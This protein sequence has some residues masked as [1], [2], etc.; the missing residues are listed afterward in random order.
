MRIYGTLISIV[1]MLLSFSCKEEVDELVN[2]V[3]ETPGDSVNAPSIPSSLQIISTTLEYSNNPTPQ[4]R[5]SGVQIG[6]LV[7]VYTNRECTNLVGSGYASSNYADITISALSS[8][9]SYSFYSNSLNS[10]DQASDCSSASVNYTLDRVPPNL[11]TNIFINHPTSVE[12]NDPTPNITVEG[13]SSG[14][15]VKIFSDSSCTSIK[16]TATA[17]SSSVEVTSSEV[18]EGTHKFYVLSSDLAG[19]SSS[20][21][22]SFATY[23]YPE[24]SFIF[25]TSWSINGK[26]S[27]QEDKFNDL[28]LDGKGDIYATGNTKAVLPSIVIGGP[29][30]LV[31]KLTNSGELLWARHIGYFESEYK[32]D[33]ISD[34]HSEE[35]YSISIDSN[36]YPYIGGKTTNDFVYERSPHPTHGSTFADALVAKIDPSDGEIIWAKQFGSYHAD[37]VTDM[38]INSQGDIIVVGI[39]LGNLFGNAVG[40]L[41]DGGDIFL[42]KLDSSNGNIIQS[43]QYGS[44]KGDRVASMVLDNQDNVYITG[45]TSG[46]LSGNTH[47]EPNGDIFISKL[48]SSFS[49]EWTYQVGQTNPLPASSVYTYNPN[50]YDS[51]NGIA[52]DSS[53]NVYCGGGTGGSLADKNSGY[54]YRD[55]GRYFGTDFVILKLNNS[56]SLQWLKQF[57]YTNPYN[58]NISFDWVGGINHGTGSCQDL[59]IDNSDN[60]ICL[61]EASTN[62]GDN[63]ET[64]G[65]NVLFLSLNS[66]GQLNW[67]RQFGKTSPFLNR[68]S[69]YNPASSGCLGGEIDTDGHI[70][71]AGKTLNELGSSNNWS[72]SPDGFILKI[73]PN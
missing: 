51:C 72:S 58:I 24:L 68:P 59:L 27:S 32:S 37:A 10:L 2:Q 5:V 35:M 40:G 25:Q 65:G 41:N 21:S 22:S 15:T 38:A 52:L 28:A 16:G 23:T 9:G 6:H 11:P 29:D 66:S 17:T 61:A 7:K 63:A 71:C 13:V 44:S 70:Y 30:A 60:I 69:Y 56:G 62:I 55:D 64:T 42:A 14:D 50:R 46:N 39:T 67:G 31:I 3:P 36:D 45:N 4:I 18:L 20:C 43:F 53:N 49:L 33:G 34:G 1:L 12:S 57:G 26:Q 73:K 47:E 8:D 19:N 48:N 54:H